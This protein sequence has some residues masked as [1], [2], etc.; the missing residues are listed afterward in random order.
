M[1]L[2]N[3]PLRVLVVDDTVLYRKIVSDVL[4]EIPGV[5]VVGSAHNG[6]AAV[7]KLAS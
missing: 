5:E 1:P 2:N 4:A 6:K 3:P 7:T